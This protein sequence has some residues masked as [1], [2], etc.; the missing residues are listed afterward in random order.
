VTR[1]R[2]VLAVVLL[3]A[4]V[5]ALVLAVGGGDSAGDPGSRSTLRAT[6]T[7]ASGNGTLQRG[8]G[9]P[10][11]NRTDLA[12]AR[13]EGRVLAT[14]GHVTDAHVRDEESPAR[15]FVLDRLGGPFSSTFRP[16]EAL[17]TQTL[18][19]AV[20]SL[21]R[22]RPDAV[23]EGGDLIDNAQADE[24]DQALAV[25]R[26]GLVHPDTGAPGYDGPQEATDS[27]PFLYRPDLDAPRHPGLLS[28]AQRPFRSP[29]L[30]APWYPVMG[31]H[32]LLVQGEAAPSPALE[33]LATGGRVLVQPDRGIRLPR[34][35]RDFDQATLNRLLAHGLPGGTERVPADPRR[36]LLGAREEVARLRAAGSAPAGPDDRLDY[37][38]PVGSGVQVIALDLIDRTRGADPQVTPSTLAWLRRALDRAGDRWVVVATHQ[39]LDSSPSGRSVLDELDRHPRVAAVLNG[40]THTNRIRPRH[41]PAG[42]YWLITTGSLADYPEQSRM[43][44]LRETSGGGLAIDTWMLDG[45]PGALADTSRALAYLDAQGGR[46]QRD[47]GRPSDRNVRLFLARR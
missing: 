19:A 8:P 1:A 39:P 28:A 46:P 2:A 41:T 5:V 10:M 43:L 11:R 7:D 6:F 32:D 34:D 25:L 47:I 23:I 37:T 9:E 20:E 4:A 26:G 15:A 38:F 44:R 3:A 13:R 45:A 22:A 30:S 31:N 21:D 18:A 42:G 36:R 40:D 33:R 35:R 27:D 17:S 24:L 14:L 29:G 16:Q 12:P